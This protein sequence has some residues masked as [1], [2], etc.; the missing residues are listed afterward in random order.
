MDVS[1]MQRDVKKTV[2]WLCC[3]CTRGSLDWIARSVGF[4]NVHRMSRSRLE[5]IAYIDSVLCVPSEERYTITDAMTREVIVKNCGKKRLIDYVLRECHFNWYD[6]MVR[7]IHKE[8][9][10]ELMVAPL[11]KDV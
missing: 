10:H 6:E 11:R 4:K 3:S 2:E 1:V 5:S 8:S 7:P 9:R